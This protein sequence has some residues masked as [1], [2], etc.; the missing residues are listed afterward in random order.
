MWN[1][2][3]W[4]RSLLAYICT[5][6]MR[7]ADNVYMTKHCVILVICC[8][9]MTLCRSWTLTQGVSVSCLDDVRTERGFDIRSHLNKNWKEVNES[10]ILY[11]KYAFKSDILRTY[12][13]YFSPYEYT[14][15]TQTIN[16]D[17]CTNA[18]LYDACGSVVHIFSFVSVVYYFDH[19][20]LRQKSTDK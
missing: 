3:V 17:E 4:S 12:F 6:H 13:R 18:E 1:L 15:H 20:L 9:P 14:K 10:F 5:V 8:L 7:K 19:I 11:F 2:A 16:M